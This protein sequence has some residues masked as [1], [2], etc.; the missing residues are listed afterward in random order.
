MAKIL[1]TGNGF[2]L[3]Y[4]LPTSFNDFIK[5]INF[6]LDNNTLVSDKTF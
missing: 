2:D 4:G 5:I 6:I 3:E 1:I